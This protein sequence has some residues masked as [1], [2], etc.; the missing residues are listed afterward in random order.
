MRTHK[1]FLILLLGLGLLLAACKPAGALQPVT[2]NLTYIPNVQFAPMYVGVEKGFFAEVGLDV[3]FIYGNE[4]D[5]LAMIGAGQEQFM[6]ASGEQ[7]LLSRAQGMPVVNV[8]EWYKDYPVAVAAPESTPLASPADL[9]GLS[10]GLPGT[11]GANYIGF[12]ALAKAAGLTDKDYKLESIGFTQVEAL[13]SGQVDAVVVYIANEPVQLQ[14]RGYPVNLLRVSDH[15]ALVGNGLVT[16]QQTIDKDPELVRKITDAFLKTMRYTAENPDEAF[17]IC[18]QYVDN[19]TGDQAEVQ[20]QVLLES[21]KLWQLAGYSEKSAESW[22]NMQNLLMDLG[23]LANP[24]VVEEA[25]THE[26]VR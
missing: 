5:M 13:V 21:I 16:N 1:T 2:L 15:L 12:E 11:Y 14:A 20:K 9:A 10:I 23:M 7:V 22:E 25:Y 3:S 4:A 26:F 17:Q 24:V 18:T 6:I 19:L 8:L